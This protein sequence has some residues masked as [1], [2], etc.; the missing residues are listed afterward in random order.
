MISPTVT[1]AIV[2][3]PTY[4]YL[5]ILSRDPALPRAQLDELIGRAREMGFD[6]SRLIIVDQSKNL[7]P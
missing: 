7:S 6:T 5:W 1:R 2:T 4:N 3:G